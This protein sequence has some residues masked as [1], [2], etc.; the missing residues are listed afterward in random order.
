[1]HPTAGQAEVSDTTFGRETLSF[2]IEPAIK[3]SMPI[4]RKTNSDISDL[5]IILLSSG[6]HVQVPKTR[7]L[8]CLNQPF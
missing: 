4:D 5:R 1:M 2:T 7:Y 6:K 3:T 8:H